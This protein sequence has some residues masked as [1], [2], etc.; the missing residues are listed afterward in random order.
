V[1][2]HEQFAADMIATSAKLAA[3]QIQFKIEKQ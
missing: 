2:T 1:T 3:E